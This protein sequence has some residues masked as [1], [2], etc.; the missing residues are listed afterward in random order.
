[1]RIGVEASSLS[2]PVNGVARVIVET[3]SEMVNLDPTA[4]FI[5]YSPRSLLVSPEVERCRIR[6]GN[7]PSYCSGSL[8]TQR[9]LPH[10][11][12]EDRIE[13]FWGHNYFLP[14]RL[15]R[16]VFR[17]LTV[18]DLIPF[19]HPR[20][21][22]FRSWLMARLLTSTTLDVADCI[23]VGSEAAAKDVVRRHPGARLKTC[24]IPWGPAESIAR[25]PS[26][27]ALRAA[28]GLCSAV[29]HPVLYV[30]G[31]APRKGLD[32]LLEALQR[33][34][35]RVRAVVVGDV[36]TRSRHL[37][38]ELAL[39]ERT[40]LVRL[41][42]TVSDEVLAALYRSCRLLVLPSQC[43]G[44]GLPVV[45]AMQCGC[46]VLCSN[47]ASLR[48]VGGEA[49]QCFRAGDASDLAYRMTAML[50][51]SDLLATMGEQGRARAAQFTFRD[52]ARKML[53]IVRAG[54]E[55]VP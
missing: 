14:V 40:G 54:L 33:C 50:A 22:P 7:L 31:A 32:V 46:P 48:E 17:L 21:V 47:D 45:E 3:V 53:T 11:L 23:T 38:Q 35:R 24:T 26:D 49:V 9:R 18:H 19:H 43:E 52:A 34:G 37:T 13:A 20:L 27:Q 6:H 10:W 44:F 2:L 29:E 8:W 15:S 41:A 25:P 51:S 12:E 1:M 30:G 39:A 28:A 5:L 16:A 42:G 55:G 4:E 36:R